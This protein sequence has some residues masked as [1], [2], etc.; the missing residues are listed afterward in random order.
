MD[1]G[2]LLPLLHS[3]GADVRLSSWRRPWW[4]IIVAGL[5]AGARCLAL[6]D[7]AGL[8]PIPISRLTRSEPVEFRREIIPILRASCLPCHNQ[9]SSKGELLLETPVQMI[10]GGESGPAIVAGRAADSLLLKLASH[11]QK[12]RMPPKENKVNAADLTPG[13]LGLLALWIDQGA[14]DSGPDREVIAWQTLP[15]GSPSNSRR[16]FQCQCWLHRV[17]PRQ[18]DRYLSVRLGGICRPGL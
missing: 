5:L 3:D 16:R 13:Q 11:A 10:K 9:T 17:R 8:K 1:A 12:P 6:A 18:S 4:W 2:L 15:P 14:H 7:E